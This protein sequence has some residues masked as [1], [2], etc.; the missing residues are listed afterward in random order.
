MLEYAHT[1]F[2]KLISMFFN[3]NEISN[4]NEF[5]SKEQYFE[6]K[7]I[8]ADY[9]KFSPATSEEMFLY[10]VM[11]GKDLRFCYTDI[12]NKTKLN[13]GRYPLIW[14]Y[15]NNLNAVKRQYDYADG[16]FVENNYYKRVKYIFNDLFTNQQIMNSFKKV[17]CKE[18][19]LYFKNQPRQYLMDIVY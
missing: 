8:W 9:I 1:V 4:K 15:L 19:A 11:L 12:T 7:K 18:V 14:K 16:S 5:I 13:N 10:L 17:N 3:T 6:M 2:N